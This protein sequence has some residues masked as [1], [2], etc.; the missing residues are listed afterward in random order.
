M[1][2]KPPGPAR[3]ARWPV[4]VALAFGGIMLAAGILLFVSAHWDELSPFQRMALLVAAVGGFHVGGRIL[5]GTISRP[6]HHSACGRHR[7]AGRR[8]RPGR[9]DFQYAGTLAH[10]GVVVGRGRYRRMA[11]AARLAATCH[12]G[13][14]DAVVAVGRM[15]GGGAGVRQSSRGERGRPDARHLLP[16]C[17]H[18]GRRQPRRSDEA[19]ARVDRRSGGAARHGHR[20]PQRTKAGAADRRRIPR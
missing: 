3:R 15:D 6:R 10:R 9:A 4:I 8:D 11:A 7:R 20:R 17:P 19:G 1:P 2:S 12:G 18:A 14:P 16:E 5:A 13:H